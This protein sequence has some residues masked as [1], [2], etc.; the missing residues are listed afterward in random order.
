[1]EQ[2]SSSTQCN[3][4]WKNISPSPKQQTSYLP[5]WLVFFDLTNQFN[6]V[7]HEA[8]FK[9]IADS[10]PEI[11]FLTTLFYEHMRSVHH[12]WADGTWCTLLVEEAV[13]QGC[14]LSP[15]CASRVVA[16]LLQP[17]DIELRERA[18]TRLKNGDPGDD[19]FGGITH[20]PGYVNNVFACIPLV[21]LQFLCDQF[22]TIGAPLGCFANPMKTRILTSTSAHSPL[23][24]L[25]QINPTLATS[26][27]DTISRYSAKM[28]DIDILGP[29][30]S[31]KLT[32][33]FHL[34]GS[35]AGSPAF[36]R[37]Y[38]NTQLIDI[39]RISD[40]CLQERERAP[41]SW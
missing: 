3:Y 40:C 30:L 31:T 1:M 37:E 15:I 4:R 22:A 5:T 18:T 29:P 14:P 20:L 25:H 39:V 16:N 26:I 32:T 34:V 17:L 36:A 35:P 27:S 19:G 8:F 13:S 11:L 38:V 23:P 9:V 10:F 6:S 28:N 12:K 24:D 7:S 21:D 41:M 2:T 33:G